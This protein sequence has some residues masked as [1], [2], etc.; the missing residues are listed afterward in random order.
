MPL[1]RQVS[2]AATDE[3]IRNKIYLKAHEYKC[4]VLMNT[5]AK[6]TSSSNV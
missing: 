6:Y 1:L 2:G 3:N 4:E 5:N